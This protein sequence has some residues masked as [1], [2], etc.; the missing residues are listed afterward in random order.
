MTASGYRH[1]EA[2]VRDEM[3]R[4][5]AERENRP[6]RYMDYG[7][8]PPAPKPEDGPQLVDWALVGRR[9]INLIIIHCLIAAA[10]LIAITVR[11]AARPFD[12]TRPAEQAQ[13]HPGY[14]MTIV[15]PHPTYRKDHR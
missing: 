6:P 2:A 8:W 9:A 12:L 14:S 7:D 4:I 10:G 3:N 13:P 15:S 1:P 11:D 5:L